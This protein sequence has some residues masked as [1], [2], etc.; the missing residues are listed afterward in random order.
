[1]FHGVVI[2]QLEVHGMIIAPMKIV[3]EDTFW[4]PKFGE[5]DVEPTTGNPC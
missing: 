5:A 2:K 3:G 4:F 1:M